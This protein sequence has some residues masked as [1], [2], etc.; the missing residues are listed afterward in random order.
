MDSRNP[1]NWNAKND[2]V[3]K[4][5]DNPFPRQPTGVSAICPLTKIPFSVKV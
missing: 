1:L 2:D 3:G 4:I 5:T